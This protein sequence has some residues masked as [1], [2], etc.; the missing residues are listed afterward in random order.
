M[1]LQYRVGG[2][3]V[4]VLEFQKPAVFNVLF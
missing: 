1:G 2:W 3:V 4:W